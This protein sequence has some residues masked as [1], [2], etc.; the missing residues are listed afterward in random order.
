MTL[1]LTILTGGSRGMGLAMA[2]QLLAPGH[3]LVSIARHA[4]P[5]L[6]APAGAQLEQ[7]TLDLA[8]GAQAAGQLQSWLSAQGAGRYASATLI[9]NA[10]VIPPIAPL[11][12]SDVHEVARALRV[13]LEAPMQL[14][15]AF[16]AATEGWGVPRKVLNVSSGLGRRAMASQAAYCAAK[17]GMDHFTRCLALD[18]AAKPHGARVCSLAPGVID[19]DMQVQLRSA[20]A[21][22]FPDVGNFAQ[23]KSSGS[24]TSPEEAAR[25]VL[26][27][28]ARPDFGANPVADVRDA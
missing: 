28:L 3:T 24:L 18:E 8:D 7:W 12:A 10:G 16:L 25:R 11:S 19:T 23:L 2:R 5:E 6:A 17:A 1:H 21:A 14:T 13:G 22:D 20:D 26:A 9:N 27:W 4:N 15:A